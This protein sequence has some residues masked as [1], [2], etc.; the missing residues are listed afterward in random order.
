MLITMWSYLVCAAGAL[1]LGRFELHTDDA[2]VEA[3]AVLLLAALLGVLHPRRAWQ[4]ALLL[5]PAIPLAD[6]LFRPARPTGLLPLTAFVILLGLA[7]SY[8]G[9]LL[10]RTVLPAARH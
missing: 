6:L 10:R 9:V 5:G 8:A 4:W 3:F 1:L 7:G 2:G